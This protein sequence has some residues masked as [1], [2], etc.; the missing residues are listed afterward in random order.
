MVE[1]VLEPVAV[2]VGQFPLQAV[3]VEV[4]PLPLLPPLFMLAVGLAHEVQ[5]VVVSCRMSVCCR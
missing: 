5:T 2:P 1:P 3:T 4:T